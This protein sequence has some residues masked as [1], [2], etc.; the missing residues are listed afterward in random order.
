VAAIRLFW[1][2]DQETAVAVVASS[3]EE[4]LAVGASELDYDESEESATEQGLEALDSNDMGEE[5]IGFLA[6]WE[7]FTQRFA[8]KVLKDER[9]RVAQ[10][11]PVLKW[12]KMRE[13]RYLG[14]LGDWTLDAYDDQFVVLYRGIDLGGGRAVD[15]AS[16]KAA[17]VARLRKIGVAFRVEDGE[18]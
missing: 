11:L 15:L 8:A 5:S 9:Q 13:G 18:Q 4:A 1:V 6:F 10:E 14:T 12:R 3:K 17:A 16:A 2:R 7:E